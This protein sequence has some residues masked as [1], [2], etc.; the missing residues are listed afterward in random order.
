MP[1]LQSVPIV[2]SAH[3]A[4]TALGVLGFAAEPQLG[5]TKHHSTIGSRNISGTTIF[6]TSSPLTNSADTPL[7]HT[8]P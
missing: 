2:N 1:V 6:Y 8:H 4:R 7:V 3:P 5:S